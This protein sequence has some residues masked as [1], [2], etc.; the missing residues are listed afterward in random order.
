MC[1]SHVVVGSII[2]YTRT[3]SISVQAYYACHICKFVGTKSNITLFHT[4]IARFNFE[5]ENCNE[6]NCLASVYIYLVVF[7]YVQYLL[8][9]SACQPCER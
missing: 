8:L 9:L 6:K 3:C 2:L 4:S 1:I 5:V 7:P